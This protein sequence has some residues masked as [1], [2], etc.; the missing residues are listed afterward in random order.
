[1]N[2]KAAADQS[3]QTA[4]R[5]FEESAQKWLADAQHYRDAGKPGLALACETQ[6]MQAQMWALED[7]SRSEKLKE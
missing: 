4:A 3:H 2:W 1:M 6:A 7:Q 5:G